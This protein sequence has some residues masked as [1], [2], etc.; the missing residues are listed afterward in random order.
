MQCFCENQKRAGVEIDTLYVTETAK[1]MT[2]F[3]EEGVDM[4]AALKS[5]K[6][7]SLVYGQSIAF[8]IIAIN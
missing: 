2:N 6:M 1:T 7:T 3:P 4:C 5:D 8:V